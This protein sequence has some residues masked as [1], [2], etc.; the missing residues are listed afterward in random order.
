MLKNGQAHFKNLAAFAAIFLKCARIF[1]H[2]IHKRINKSVTEK[3]IP[4]LVQGK[5]IV[6]FLEHCRQSSILS[7]RNSLC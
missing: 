6:A 3:V 5:Y 2:V 1:R 7:L 4:C